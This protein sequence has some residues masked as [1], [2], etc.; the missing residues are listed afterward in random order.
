LLSIHNIRTLIRVITAL[1]E[2]IIQ[3][4]TELTN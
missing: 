4:G 2:E 1:R 3:Y